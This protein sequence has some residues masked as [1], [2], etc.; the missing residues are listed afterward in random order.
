M[1]TARIAP[2]WLLGACIGGAAGEPCDQYCDYICECHTGEAEFDCDQC[3][4]EYAS[5][6]AELGDE[7][8]ATL[9]DLQAQDVAGG[10]GCE[11]SADDTGT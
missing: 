4:T 6:D 2:L 5:V 1:Y 8:E 3:R 11:S 10:T 9:G 7:C